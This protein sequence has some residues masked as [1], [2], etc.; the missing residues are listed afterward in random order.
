MAKV[1]VEEFVSRHALCRQILTDQG[2]QFESKL[3]KEICRLLD[4][5]KKRSTSFH[6]QTNGIQ[7]RFNRTI[8]D[9]L[10]KYISANQR[11]WDEHLPLLLLAYR[12]SVH[13]STQQTPFM[14][15]YGRH[16]ILPID[17][18]CPQSNPEKEVSTNEYVQLLK[19]RLEKVH[20]FARSDMAKA[21]D[22]Q[23]KTYDHCVCVVPYSVGDQVWLRNPLKTKGLCPKL[24][25]RWEGPYKI[26]R[27][28]SDLVLE[29][30][31]FKGSK[32]H[33]KIVHKN[34]LKRYRQ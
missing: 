23:K 25:P 12:S 10:S 26:R 1:F 31:K 33:R 5:D 34:R 29:I 21:S 16:A 8:E 2:A 14:M 24:Q 9:M 17:L 27:Q 28:I 30:E 3:F 7:E 15:M 19:S 20:N 13:E 6:P 22:R 32:F 18:T 4:I 11:D